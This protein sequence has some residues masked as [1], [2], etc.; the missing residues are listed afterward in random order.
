MV[1][2]GWC[3]RWQHHTLRS[4]DGRCVSRWADHTFGFVHVFIT[5]GF[6]RGEGFTTAIALEPMTSQANAL[7]SGVGLR[8]LAPGDTLSASWAIRYDDSALSS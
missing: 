7:N 6:P 2:L 1:C 8:W 4:P 3:S 5:R